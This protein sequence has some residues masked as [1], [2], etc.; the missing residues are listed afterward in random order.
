MCVTLGKEKKNIKKKQS[1]SLEE[2]TANKMQIG[3]GVHTKNCYL[4]VDTPACLKCAHL[5]AYKRFVIHF[6]VLQ[7]LQL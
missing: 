6:A 2:L 1:T 5:Y 4:R 3:C 7:I